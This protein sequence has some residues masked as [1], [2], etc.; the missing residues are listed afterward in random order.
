V[1]AVEDWKIPHDGKA[2]M[3][4]GINKMSIFAQLRNVKRMV[5]AESDIR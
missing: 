1:Q 5:E 4:T 3:L 2:G